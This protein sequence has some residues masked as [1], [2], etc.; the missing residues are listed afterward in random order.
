MKYGERI[1][2]I[3]IFQLGGRIPAGTAKIRDGP[4]FSGI[5]WSSNSYYEVEYGEL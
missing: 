1:S 3:Y 4:A 5:K 2:T